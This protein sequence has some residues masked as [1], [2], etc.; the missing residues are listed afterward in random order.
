MCEEAGEKTGFFRHLY[1]KMMIL[2]RQA[3]DKHR[4]NS[5]KR[6]FFADGIVTGSLSLAITVFST[7]MFLSPR[8]QGISAGL[9]V[10]HFRPYQDA[11]L[12]V[13]KHAKLRVDTPVH[14][15]T[16]SA[17]PTV[18]MRR[19]KS[20]EDW[21]TWLR[22]PAGR[23]RPHDLSSHPDIDYHKITRPT[24][25]GGRGSRFCGFLCRCLSCRCCRKKQNA[26]LEA[27]DAWEG[28]WHLFFDAPVLLREDD[29]DYTED[30]E[31]LQ[32][33]GWKDFTAAEAVVEHSLS[34]GAA[35]GE[36]CAGDSPSTAG[37]EEEEESKTG[38]EPGWLCGE[39]PTNKW[40]SDVDQLV[41]GRPPSWLMVML[42]LLQLRVP[43]EGLIA[44]RNVRMLKR[45]ERH[46]GSMEV[47]AVDWQRARV[48][49]DKAMLREGIFE[50]LPQVRALMIAGR[51]LLPC[52][53]LRPSL[54]PARLSL[55]LTVCPRHCC[56]RCR[57]CHHRHR[58]CWSSKTYG[59]IA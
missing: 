47:R 11:K 23:H 33:K 46:H 58:L 48:D 37:D 13:Y 1:M 17:E 56:R 27:R 50:I 38:R 43:V 52:C 34:P 14:A 36:S 45:R 49:L 40:D 21:H 10:R 35:D 53:W 6:P 42:T 57:V 3:R 20:A 15:S 16:D 25:G 32:G 9:G 44:W 28:S 51:W 41:Y 54:G 55:T 29:P 22:T 39:P 8:G 7:F 59:R 12:W 24:H 30:L 19:L 5:K 2:P 26:A 18:H 4:E 31:L